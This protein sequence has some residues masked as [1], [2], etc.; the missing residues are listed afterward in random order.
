[1]GCESGERDPGGSAIASAIAS[2]NADASPVVGLPPVTGS[3]FRSRLNHDEDL[4]VKLV[5]FRAISKPNSGVNSLFYLNFVSANGWII[6]VDNTTT[7]TNPTEIPSIR[8]KRFIPLNNC[9]YM[10]WM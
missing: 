9:R 3:F 2:A 10:D 7:W 5:L 8:T 1:M 6:K 4:F